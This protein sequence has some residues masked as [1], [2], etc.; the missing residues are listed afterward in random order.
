MSN[1]HKRRIKVIDGRDFYLGKLNPFDTFNQI[2]ITLSHIFREKTPSLGNR[3][4]SDCMLDFL[5]RHE[6]YR[7]Q[8][9]EIGCG[10]GDLAF[11][12]VQRARELDQPIDS[13]VIYDISPELLRVEQERLGDLATSFVEADCLDLSNQISSFNGLVISNGMLADLKSVLISEDDRPTDYGINDP[14]I[15][16][17]LKSWSPDTDEFYLHIGTLLFLREISKCLEPEAVAVITEYA[18]T[19]LNQPSPFGGHYECGIDFDQI[20]AYAIRLDFEVEVVDIEEVLGISR[21]QEF[22]SMDV[23]TSQ[24]RLARE[25]PQSVRIWQGEKRLPVLAYTRDSLREALCSPDIG[26]GPAEVNTVVKSLEKYF[27]PIHDPRFDHKNPTTWGYKCLILRKKKMGPEIEE[28]CEAFGVSVLQRALG[29]SKDDARQRW[30][31]SVSNAQMGMDLLSVT[32]TAIG[33][34]ISGIA[35]DLVKKFG[36]HVWHFFAEDIIQ[37]RFGELQIDDDQRMAAQKA[38]NV[39]LARLKESKGDNT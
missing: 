38:A 39:E 8:V 32:E 27:H 26:L 34:V 21:D 28:L 4:Y 30:K 2:E 10:L 9:V 6:L 36:C 19:D 15:E 31:N 23:F 25:V 35:Y 1:I 24:D 33:A 12:F 11:N 20:S 14:E 7:S 5:N 29:L 16:S 17:F 13:Y 22:L 18:A 3:N 37:E